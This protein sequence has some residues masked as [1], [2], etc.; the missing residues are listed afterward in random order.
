MRDW[1]GAGDVGDEADSLHRFDEGRGV[2][3]GCCGEGLVAIAVEAVVCVSVVQDVLLLLLVQS[4]ASRVELPSV[5]NLL[6]PGSCTNLWL[7]LRPELLSSREEMWL[8]LC[9]SWPVSLL[10]SRAAA[11]GVALVASRN[12]R[13][14]LLLDRVH[15]AIS[16]AWGFG[17]FFCSAVIWSVF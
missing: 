7:S 15:L 16:C 4:L 2:V 14:L 6:P 3:L 12:W 10:L 11:D 1:W 17:W 13:L 5:S 8:L 9:S